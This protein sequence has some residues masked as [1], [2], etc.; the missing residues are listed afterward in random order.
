MMRIRPYSLF[1]CLGALAAFGR[2]ATLPEVLAKIDTAGPKFTGMTANVDE[3]SYSKVIDDKSTESGTIVIWRPKPKDLQIKIEFTKPDQRFVT[4]KGQKAEIYMPKIS[5]VQE[6]DLGK[7]SDLITKV[8]L[9]GL[10]TTGK[11]LQA[12]YEVSLLGEESVSGRNT[13]HLN[14]VPKAANLKKQ[15]RNMEAWIVDDGSF[16][17]QQKVVLPAGDY[18]M[19]TYSN[20][21]YN[22]ALTEK[23]LALKLPNNVK[24]EYP[25]RDR[26]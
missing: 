17:M 20:A 19:F 26:N 14:L 4:L 3:L 22:P 1:L 8:M 11:E 23:A 7:Q 21:I 2:A 16:P 25:Q 9:V 5:T 6:Y 10:G 15:F 13:Y 18:K 24:R 12:N